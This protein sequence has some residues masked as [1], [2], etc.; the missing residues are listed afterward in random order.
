MTGTTSDVLVIGSGAAGLTAALAL[1][2]RHKV[3]VLA[4]GPLTCGLDRLGAGRHRRGARCRRHVRGAYPRHDDRRRGAQPAR[5]GR[6]RHRAR[7]RSDRAA[8]PARRALQHRG[9]D[10][11]PDPRGRAQPPPHRP[12]QRCDRLGGAGRAAQGGG[13][14]PQHHPAAR[15]HL[16]RP[17]HRARTK[18]RYSGS[19]R[20][21][22]AYALDTATRQGRGLYRARHGHGVGRCGPGLPVLDRAARS[23]RRR[24][25]HGLAR[26]GAGL[27]HGIHAVPPD[28]PVQ[29]RGQELPHHRGGARRGRAADQPGHRRALHGALRPRA[30]G[31]GPARYRRPG[32]RRPDQ[33]LRSRLRP[34]RHQPPAARIRPRAFPD[35]PREAAR[36][37]HRHDEAADPGRARAALHLR[38][39][40]DRARRT[41]RSAGAMGGGRVHRERAARR[42][43]PRVEQPARMLRVR[44]GGGA[45]HPRLLGQARRGRRRSARGTKAA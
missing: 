42:Q 26:R 28:L 19:G 24:H 10:A 21:W 13:G 34:S 5:D 44:R 23:D 6:I 39:R 2:Q 27:E 15:P 41:H 1:A 17:D 31:T 40:A 30:D 22:G 11:A 9:A 20:V 16:H 45:R 37:R 29:S 38:R 33:A 3:T 12:C 36:P 14:K 4:K 35:D 8:G 25:R 43:P 32:Q 7:A 18:Q